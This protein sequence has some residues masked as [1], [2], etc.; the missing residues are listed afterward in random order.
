MNLK[1][2]YD[3]LLELRYVPTIGDSADESL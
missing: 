2:R 1:T 3:Q